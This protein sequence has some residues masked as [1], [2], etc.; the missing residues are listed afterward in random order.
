MV[1]A[2][3]KDGIISQIINS[4]DSIDKLKKKFGDVRQASGEVVRSQGFTEK[5]I[6]WS[7]GEVKP[8]SDQIKE[9]IFKISEGFVLDGE[10]V[11]SMTQVERIE[12]GLDALPDGMK[13]E[14]GALVAMTRDE[15]YDAGH[16]TAAQYNA[17][18][19]AERQARY[20]IEAD[21]LYMEYIYDTEAGKSG[22]A[23]KKKIWIDKVTEIK[24]ALPLKENK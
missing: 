13:I 9:G 11:R 8:L 20:T 7:T 1:Y 5:V 24:E 14:G 21:S 2:I 3:I 23:A 12:A 15:R 19:R 22:A 17:E 16:I 4:A 6:D 18:A 10:T